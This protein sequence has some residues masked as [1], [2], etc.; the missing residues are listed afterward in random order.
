MEAGSFAFLN[1][2]WGIFK[3]LC[4]SEKYNKNFYISQHVV[5]VLV[6]CDPN[7]ITPIDSLPI[8]CI[9]LPTCS[10]TWRPFQNT[11]TLFTLILF[12]IAG[13]LIFNLNYS[14]YI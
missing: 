1:F 4:L 14:T 8:G 12:S 7:S 9:G 11:L 6:E 3:I 10:Y 2:P 5:L 13:S